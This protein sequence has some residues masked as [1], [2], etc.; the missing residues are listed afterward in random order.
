[1]TANGKT[2]DLFASAS[3]STQRPRSAR[4]LIRAAPALEIAR[5]DSLPPQPEAHPREA[6]WLALTLPGLALE[7]LQPESNRQ[8]QLHRQFELS[9][10]PGSPTVF[11]S[12]PASAFPS[13]PQPTVVVDLSHN[14][15]LVVG[16]NAAAVQAGI[17]LGI[18]LNSA[19]A[20]AQDLQVLERDVA[21]ERRLLEMLAHW[22]G[23]FTP[24]VALEPPDGLLL[25][26]KGSLKLFGG[27]A[28]LQELIAAR[29]RARGVQSALA[30]APTP[31]AAL[32]FSRTHRPFVCLQR[33][34]LPAAL[35]GVPIA[36][37]RWNEATVATLHAMGAQKIGDC[38]R[39]PRAGFARRFGPQLLLQLDQLLGRAAQVQR[40]FVARERFGLRRDF[41][42]DLEGHAALLLHLQPPLHALE[43][44]L[45]PRQ[46]GVQSL[47]V[48]LRHRD[49]ASTRVVLRFVRPTADAAHVC[50]VLSERLERL[51]LP[52]PVIAVRLRSGPLWPLEMEIVAHPL[53]T[54][55]RQSAPQALTRLIERLRARLGDDSVQGLQ[56]VAEHRPER[57]SRT[58]EPA[59]RARRKLEV[60]AAALPAL[61]RPFWLLPQPQP[62]QTQRSWPELEGRL[63]LLQGPERIESGWWD[64][65]DICRDYYLAATPQGLRVWVYRERRSKRWFLHGVYG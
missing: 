47:E 20:L 57:A 44:F 51:E 53:L 30:I 17:A 13:S 59:V 40:T 18:G 22:A 60:E 4:E 21:A 19:Y 48:R 65:D 41:E 24:K 23:C 64:G 58:S 43:S 6:L 49:R 32:V 39:L 62:L 61:P 26:I 27:L 29:L 12:A 36:T 50:S 55:P 14:Q 56:C 63:D 8:P 37:L 42:V 34:Q 45:R 33:S 25:E 9:R 10:Q 2:L 35:A 5:A 46:A 54:D 38:L 52:A 7:A 11:S 3:G 31:G 15:Q 1:M 28:S 16:C